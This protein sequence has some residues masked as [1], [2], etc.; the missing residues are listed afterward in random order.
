MAFASV[1][2]TAKS[3]TTGGLVSS[4]AFAAI[5]LGAGRLVVV[6]QKWEGGATTI[7]SVT[8][9]AGN[10]YSSCT[11]AYDAA[12]GQ[13]AQIWYCLSST[14]NATNVVTV[15]FSGTTAQYLVGQLTQ[16]SYTGTASLAGQAATTGSSTSPSSGSFTAGG[17]AIGVISEF[18]GQNATPGTGWTEDQDTPGAGG[19]TFSRYD[20]PGGTIV[21]NATLG[22][23]AAWAAAGAA[24]AESGGGGSAEAYLTMAPMRPATRIR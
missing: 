10:T 13:H 14:A 3:D 20:S 5:N 23:S 8:D 18:V 2:S 7:T 12:N 24:F 22:S 17:M 21:A 11:A 1:T 6:A 16:A 4:V 19:H 15:N 9:T